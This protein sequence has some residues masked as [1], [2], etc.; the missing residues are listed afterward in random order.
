MKKIFLSIALAGLV[1]SSS[2]LALNSVNTTSTEIGSEKDG[3]DKKK[4]KKKC[5]SDADKKGCDK[6]EE[7]AEKTGE[8]KVG[9]ER[10]E[11]AKSCAKEGEKKACCAKKK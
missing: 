1:M 11:K 2:A 7:G 4:K 8:Q 3:D 9:E 6:S 5:C 10:A